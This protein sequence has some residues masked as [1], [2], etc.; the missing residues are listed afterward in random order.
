MVNISPLTCT[1]STMK[2]WI[3]LQCQAG[4]PGSSTS[5]GVDKKVQTGRLFFC[6]QNKESKQNLYDKIDN[7]KYNGF[8]GVSTRPFFMKRGRPRPKSSH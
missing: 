7:G 6:R 2:Y 5:P 4:C 3:G 8:A 1:R